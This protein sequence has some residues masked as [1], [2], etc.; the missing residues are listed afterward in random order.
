MLYRDSKKIDVAIGLLKQAI[1]NE[2]PLLRIFSEVNES[3][4]LWDDKIKQIL[5]EAFGPNSPE[6]AEF[7]WS[8]LFQ[9]GRT[10]QDKQNYYLNCLNEKEI[11]LKKLIQKYEVKKLMAAPIKSQS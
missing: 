8:G 4:V 5:K 1:N 11:C 2:I 6:Y 3:Y 9:F 7:L 10:F